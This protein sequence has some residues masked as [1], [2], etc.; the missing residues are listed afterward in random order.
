MHYYFVTH[1]GDMARK[2]RK[3]S[4][5]RRTRGGRRILTTDPFGYAGASRSVDMPTT[6]PRRNFVASD[7]PTGMKKRK[8]TRGFR[9]GVLTKLR[10]RKVRQG[11]VGG[12][13]GQVT[14]PSRP[15][16]VSNRI[17]RAFA[18][19]KRVMRWQRIN[20]LNDP[21]ITSGVP[22]AI[23][24]NNWNA[25][26]TDCYAPVH[27]YSLNATWNT[28]EYWSAVCGALRFAEITTPGVPYFQ[29]I[30][31]VTNTGTNSTH[32]GWQGEYQ[33]HPTAN[34]R[35]KLISPRWYDIRMMCYGCNNQPT[36]YEIYILKFKND[37]LLPW[38]YT[39]TGTKTAHTSEERTSFWQHFG[40]GPRMFNPA[41]PTQ[42][43]N[44]LW[45]SNV[46]VL[47]R[48]SFVL[49]PSLTV[50]NDNNPE[51]KL[52]RIFQRDGRLLRYAEQGMPFTSET[53]IGTAEWTEVAGESA[54]YQNDPIRQQD[55]LFLVIRA[56][57]T[58]PVDPNLAGAI[59]RANTPSYD[60]CIR[61]K[62]TYS[63]NV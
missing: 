2:T 43:R 41:L 60:I 19:A 62:E 61:K 22:G 8:R 40:G 15:R 45:L 1:Y 42:Q 29:E 11:L 25:V 46:R 57:N 12:Q 34:Q 5:G 36:K 51:C 47:R 50:E 9:G 54:R 7:G 30:N 33:D 16:P 49:N 39:S 17:A 13:Y 55:R 35:C 14:L 38:D 10:R 4:T 28:P 48:I 53:K 44:T 3:A 37:E 32:P 52:V 63:A 21:N 20:R 59:T 31:S 24:I 23:S 6:M 18:C 26:G 27:V 56:M 58:T